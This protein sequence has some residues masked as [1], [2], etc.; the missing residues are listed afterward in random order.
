MNCTKALKLSCVVFLLA[1]PLLA[2]SNDSRLCS[3]ATLKGAYGGFAQGT[4]LAQFPGFPSPPYAGV[5]AGLHTYDGA[6]NV[7]IIYAASFGGVIMP[8]GVTAA[9]T[10]TVKWDCT[11]AVSVVSSGGLPAN[12][13]GVI[14]GS[15]ALQEVH[16][17]YTDR[18]WV[19]Y[20]TLRKTPAGGCSQ[21][22]LKGTYGLFG[23]G[24]VTLPGSPPLVPGSHVG[25]FIADG[26]GNLSGNE[27]SNIVGTAGSDN[28]TG[29][30][31]VNSDCSVSATITTNSGVV[32]EVGMI[33]GEGSLQEVHKIVM[34]PGWVFAD[35]DKKQ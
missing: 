11:V 6:G 34:E 5:V 9:G 23:D 33:T 25:R 17:T 31:T 18:Y 4:I 24:L 32:H 22:S 35:V 3:R 1:I 26:R 27:T 16:I 7:F 12:F 21:Q 14:T 28:F 29:Q 15:G 30:Y 2:Q 8:W 10:Y 20:G 13:V 19:N